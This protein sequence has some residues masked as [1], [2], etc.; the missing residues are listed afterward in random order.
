MTKRER[1]KENRRQAKAARNAEIVALYQQGKTQEEIAAAL[2]C[3]H[4]TAGRVLKAA[5][6]KTPAEY[7]RAEVCKLYAQGYKA[8][9]IADITGVHVRT[10]YKHISKARAAG[11]I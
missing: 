7:L 9:E 6:I 3:S 4:Q 5:G 2:N 10:V 11:E 1:E 8:A